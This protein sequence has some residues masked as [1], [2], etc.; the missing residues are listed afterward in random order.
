MLLKTQEFISLVIADAG[1]VFLLIFKNFMKVKLA[2]F[3]PGCIV[4]HN[5]FTISISDG[6]CTVIVGHD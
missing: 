3:S 2:K 5:F 6:S 1:P 4:Q